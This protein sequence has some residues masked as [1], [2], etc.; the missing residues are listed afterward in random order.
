[1]A[2]ATAT[3]VLSCTRDLHHS[4]QQC[5]ILNPLNEAKDRTRIFMD[6]GWVLSPLSH[7]GNSY[8]T[9]LGL[10]LCII[11]SLLMFLDFQN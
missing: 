10:S 1:M 4:L 7:T 6:T 8:A 3:L 2:T 11:L 5:R 9:N